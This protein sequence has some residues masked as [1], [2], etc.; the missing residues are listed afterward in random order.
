MKQNKQDS[1]KQSEKEGDRP[2]CMDIVGAEKFLQVQ[3][4]TYYGSLYA[5]GELNKNKMESSIEQAVKCGFIDQ[6]LLHLIPFYDFYKLKQD[7]EDRYKI[8]CEKLKKSQ[9]LE[10]YNYILKK[11][12]KQ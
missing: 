6:N 7:L 8:K 1:Q 11:I 9:A 10:S 5:A 4:Y 2:E 3:G 12:L